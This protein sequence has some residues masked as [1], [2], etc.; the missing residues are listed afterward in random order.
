MVW[1]RWIRL[2]GIWCIHSCFQFLVLCTVNMNHSWHVSVCMMYHSET[3]HT[4]IVEYCPLKC[5]NLE[6]FWGLLVEDG[7]SVTC[8]LYLFVNHY[9]RNEEDNMMCGNSS[10]S[11]KTYCKFDT[12]CKKMLWKS[13]SCAWKVRILP[14]THVIYEVGYIFNMQIPEVV[15]RQ[16]VKVVKK[17]G[18]PLT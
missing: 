1:L 6:I 2:L 12:L 10:F 15:Y 14:A 5:R 18:D 13:F 9:C 7:I 4:D 16:W 17:T 8:L 11:F 3:R